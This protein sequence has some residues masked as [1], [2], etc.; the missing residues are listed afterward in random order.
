M[1]KLLQFLQVLQPYVTPLS[2]QPF[3]K[4][5]DAS[6]Y[7]GAMQELVGLEFLGLA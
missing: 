6:Q 2:S 5:T 4:A 1:K 3:H 7:V